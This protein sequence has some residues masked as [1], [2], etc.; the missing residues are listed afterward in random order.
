MTART[1]GRSHRALMAAIFLLGAWP[2]GAGALEPGTLGGRPF[3]P[4]EER[5]SMPDS[6][7]KSPVRHA[8]PKPV[9]VALTL[10]QQIYPALLPLVE[11]FARERKV[12]IAVQEGTCGTSIAAMNEKVADIIGLCCPPAGTD[13]LPGIQWHTLGIGSL[14]L[15]VHPE[16]P[17]AAIT[18]EGARRLFAGDTRTWSELPM[19]GLKTA[20]RLDVQAV[21]RLHCKTRPGHWRLI[22]DNENLFARDVEEVAAIQDM[23]LQVSKNRGAIGYETLYHVDLFGAQKGAKVKTV[24]L[25]GI[26]PTDDRALAAGKYPFYRVFNITTWSEGPAANPLAT[27]LVTWLLAKV[28]EGALAPQFAIVPAKEL[29]AKGW[30][31]HRNELIGEPN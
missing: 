17:V 8:T 25:N 3:A 13:R 28:D 26:A 16:N 10:D 9:K 7:V 1:R 29:R 27:E 23:L 15:I 30:K 12:E 31:F 14:A 11:S 6:W 18:T 21:T 2:V 24:R 20:P 4:P 22:L 5:L 19:S